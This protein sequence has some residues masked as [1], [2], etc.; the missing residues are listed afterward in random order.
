MPIRT[1]VAQEKQRLSDQLAKLDADRS[2]LQDR[3]DELE[4]AERVLSR[5]GKQKNETTKPRRPAGGRSQQASD[6]GENA[7][8]PARG[9]GAALPRGQS[10]PLG[11]ATLRAVQ[12]HS[13]GLSA[14]SVR[15]YLAKKF[16]LEVRPNHL[17]MA[18]QRHR[19]AGRLEIR[20]SRW[21]ALQEAAG[22]MPGRAP[23]GA[24]A[25]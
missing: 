12:A 10:M 2:K 3:L 4:I 19:R 9:R 14:D 21:H 25:I 17:G 7:R 23:R 11:E 18:L 16:G 22:E 5:F 6:D 1:D 15:N 8:T 13:G 24:T 20:D